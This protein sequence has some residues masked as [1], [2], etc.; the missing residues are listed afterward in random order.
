MK[1]RLLL[2]F[3][4]AVM[5]LLLIMVFDV[6]LNFGMNMGILTNHPCQ[7][8]CWQS[9]VPGV[10]TEPEVRSFMEKLDPDEW[11]FESRQADVIVENAYSI[12]SYY[13]PLIPNDAEF[14]L[15]MKNNELRFINSDLTHVH[16][17][18]VPYLI[19]GKPDYY[20]S[21]L[22]IGPDGSGYFLTLIYLS[23]GLAFT[24]LVD[25]EKP[26]QISPFT[27]ISGI[28]YFPPGS[29]MEYY[30]AKETL[31]V[32]GEDLINFANKEITK[33]IFPWKGFGELEMGKSGYLFESK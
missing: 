27:L 15:L 5:I 11:S 6:F 12:R 23:K 29:L 18:L 2:P 14:D 25:P 20:E 26:G 16:P 17:F 4:M 7:P 10:S 1:K 9:L 24:M 19:L 31:R 32:E 30:Q 33:Y 3:L 8:P 13:E 21:I 22:A 28:S